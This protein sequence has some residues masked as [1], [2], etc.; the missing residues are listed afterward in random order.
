MAS[1]PPD[2]LSPWW[3]EIRPLPADVP[4]AVRVRRFLKSALRAYGLKCESVR[5]KPPEDAADAILEKPEAV[6][7]PVPTLARTDPGSE[8]TIKRSKEITS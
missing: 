6:P 4:A 2:D 8:G 3:I 5:G 7:D 1:D